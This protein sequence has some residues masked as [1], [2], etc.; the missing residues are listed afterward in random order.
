MREKRKDP[1]YSRRES[2]RRR[3]QLRAKNYREKLLWRKYRS[4]W[5]YLSP[6]LM[7]KILLVRNN[8]LHRARESGD[9]GVT[10]Y[11]HEKLEVK[12]KEN[13]NDS[14]EYC[15]REGKLERAWNRRPKFSISFLCSPY[16]YWLPVAPREILVFRE[17]ALAWGVSKSENVQY[18]LKIDRFYKRLF[19]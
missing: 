10:T 9:V 6:Y 7:L 11:T 3:K 17:F 1:E 14:V 18:M 15:N 13:W 12:N 16:F 2:E 4:C 8:E 5:S 19:T